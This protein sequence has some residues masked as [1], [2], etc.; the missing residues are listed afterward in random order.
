M[1]FGKSF[2]QSRPWGPV[3]RFKSDPEYAHRLFWHLLRNTLATRECRH[4]CLHHTRSA[5]VIII[6]RDASILNVHQFKNE[7]YPPST[8]ML[9]GDSNRASTT[10][11]DISFLIASLTS[12]IIRRP[13]YQHPT[14]ST[15]STQR[16]ISSQNNGCFYRCIAI[17][18]T[19]AMTTP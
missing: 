11:A 12:T 19:I 2:N 18:I 10:Y 3:F 7:I 8:V 5:C 6:D 13:S 9:R 1:F 14:S 15:T 17:S 16:R 4:S